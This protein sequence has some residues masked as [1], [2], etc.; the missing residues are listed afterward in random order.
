[1][2]LKQ[3]WQILIA[4]VLAVV[5]GVSINLGCAVARE[6]TV[7]LNGAGQTL[8]GLFDYIGT[9]FM[10]ALKMIIVPLIFSSVVVGIAGL[11]NTHGFGRLGLKTIGYYMLTSLFAIL[12]GLTL[13]NVFQPGLRDGQPNEDIAAAISANSQDYVAAAAQKVE[14]QQVTGLQSVGDIFKRMIPENVV[15]A[16]SDNSKMLSLIFVS[17][18][19]GFGILFISQSSR[20]SL[21]GFFRSL[22]ELMLLVTR[23]I[24]WTAPIGVFG[25]VAETV[26]LTGLEAFGLLAKYFFVVLG[27]LLLHLLVVLPLILRFIGRVNPWKHLAAMR[28]ALLTAFSTA[29]SSATLPVTMRCVNQNAGVSNRVTSFVLPLGA[30]I[31][32]DG[33]ALYECVAVMFIAQVLGMD[34]GFAQQFLVVALALLTSIGVAG[35]P[36]ASLVAILI[37]VNNVGIP[38]AEA[39]IGFLLAV[40]R[41]LDMSRTAVNVFSD[42]CGAAVIARSEGEELPS[43]QG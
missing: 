1:V 14:G 25:L 42:S 35:V 2:K 18:L 29:S 13:V 39:V 16:F 32:M 6:P 7:Q 4:L 20:E 11:G 33:T 31:N 9:L 37:I 40:D 27:A 19:T 22:N 12:I 21:L 23:W 43:L 10:L 30:T 36:S 8:V 17:L 5:V 15:E 26:S 34:L 28:N 41:L 38:N 3:H 24:M